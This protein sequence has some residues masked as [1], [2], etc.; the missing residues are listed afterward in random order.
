MVHRCVQH[1]KKYKK[2]NTIFIG[3]LKYRLLNYLLFVNYSLLMLTMVCLKCNKNR[4]LCVLILLV[5][6]KNYFE[7]V[8]DNKVLFMGYL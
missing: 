8:A 5:I 4:K 1:L 6:N 7:T 2:E 3:Y